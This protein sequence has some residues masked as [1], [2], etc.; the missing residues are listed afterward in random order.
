MEMTD[1][2]TSLRIIRLFDELS[3]NDI[4]LGL[5]R[6]IEIIET[7]D[8]EIPTDPSKEIR[9]LEPKTRKATFLALRSGCTYPNK[10]IDI[11]HK[12]GFDIGVILTHGDMRGVWLELVNQKKEN[13]KK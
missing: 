8:L 7:E 4:A 3:Y 11:L 1:R 2:D 12:H 6:N 9:P 10:F 13:Q 5:E